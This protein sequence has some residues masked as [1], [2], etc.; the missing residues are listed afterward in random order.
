M[1]DFPSDGNDDAVIAS[2]P[3]PEKSSATIY[4]NVFEE[5]PISNPELT[6]KAGIPAMKQ[7][8]S[9]VPTKLWE[10]PS[11]RLAINESTHL[12]WKRHLTKFKLSSFRR[13]Q[14]DAIRTVEAKRDVTFIQKTG[15]GKSICFQVRSLFEN[16]KTV[17]VI[18]PTISLIH[19][20][21]ESLKGLGID[22]VAAGP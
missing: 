7:E 18:C 17:L 12:I 15:S 6:R 9:N 21:V 8:I 19:S 4:G 16:D 13:F 5:S 14:L 20:Q 10:Y 1:E 11:A 3:E 2:L 22:A